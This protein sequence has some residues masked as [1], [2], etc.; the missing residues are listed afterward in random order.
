MKFP[1]R[2]K[3]T[4]AIGCAAMTLLFPFGLTGCAEAGADDGKLTV[5]T[6]VFASYDF[7]RQLTASLSI[8]CEVKLLLTPGGESHSYEPTPADV[9]A[10]Q[11]CDLFVYVGGASEKWADDLIATTKREESGKINVRLFDAVNPLEEEHV[12]G[13]EAE[14]EHEHEHSHAD[15]EEIEYDEH[16][17]TSPQNA[18]I[19]AAEI[20]EAVEK[21][22][23]EQSAEVQTAAASLRSDLQDLDAEYQ[24]LADSAAGDTLIFA[25]RFPFRYLTEAYGWNYYAAFAGCSSDTDASAATLSF[26]ISKVKEENI[27]TVFYLEN[28]TQKISDAV[29]AATDA[30]AVML[31]SCNNVSQTDF[32]SGKHYQE[33]M[34]ENLAA[35]KEALG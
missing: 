23:P 6:T 28:S 20:A 18:E 3:K 15:G 29:C 12:E 30:K 26:L 21:C 13:M 9:A 4:A 32:Q 16:I 34:R 19:I 24:A 31:Q 7:A 8:P 11:S 2:I 22:V 17:W 25:D 1:R 10:I 35:I 33:F 27:G 14:E 5:V